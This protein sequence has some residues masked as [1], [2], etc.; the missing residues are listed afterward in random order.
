MKKFAFILVALLTLAFTGCKVENSK[1]TVVVE[2][3]AGAPVANCP[4]IYADLASII[5]DAALP[6][7]EELI[8]DTQDCWEYA[9]TN[10]YGQVTINITLAVSKMNYCFMA[11]DRGSNTWVDKIVELRRGVNEEISFVVNK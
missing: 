10:N 7:P 8:T 9:E 11:Y 6:S 2:D 4:I 5:I 3:E 1:V